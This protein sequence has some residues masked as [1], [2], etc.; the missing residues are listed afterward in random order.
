MR[1]DYVQGPDLAGK[2]PQ[3][4]LEILAKTCHDCMAQ[5]MRL[6]NEAEDLKEE[7]ERLKQRY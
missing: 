4:A 5:I 2:T 1:I 6:S 3:Q 7:V